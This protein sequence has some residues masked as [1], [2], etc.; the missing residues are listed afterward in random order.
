[1]TLDASDKAF[2]KKRPGHIS[3]LL[4]TFLSVLNK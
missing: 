4:T 2:R 3:K 1:M